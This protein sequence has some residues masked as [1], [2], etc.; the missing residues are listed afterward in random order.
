MQR[1]EKVCVDV[2][3]NVCEKEW[4]PDGYGGQVSQCLPTNTERMETLMCHM[5][6]QMCVQYS[7]TCYSLAH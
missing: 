5:A 7:R 4:R 1:I 6:D 2:W 3:V